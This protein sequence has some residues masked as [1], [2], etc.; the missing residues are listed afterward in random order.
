M[1]PRELVL[2]V[3]ARFES[4]QL[5]FGHG[6]DNARDEAV[7][8]VFHALG[9]PFDVDDDVL[10]QSLEDVQ[11][12]VVEKI[13]AERIKSRKPAAYLTGRMWFAGH[14]FH[15]D[16]RV[17]V[18]RS[19][20]AELIKSEFKPWLDPSRI[21]RVLEIGTGSGCIAIAAAIALPN[22][23]ID[24]TDNSADA[25]AVAALNLARY[26][27]LGDRIWFIEA[28]LFPLSNATYDLVVTNPPY[29][30]SGDVSTLPPEYAHEP[31]MALD[32]GP[33]GLTIV[34][35]ILA[36]A[37]DRLSEDG[38]I[39]IDVGEMVTAIDREIQ[40]VSFTWIDVEYGG[41]GIGIAYKRDFH[42]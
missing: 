38:A 36:Q 11:C 13:V 14:E 34:R 40:S 2:D 18:P 39:I 1:T 23:K 10:D 33:D 9:L 16:E 21:D 8:L 7:F 35:R 25:L 12:A 19:P 42:C 17:L 5:V 15:V 24:A 27:Q 20:I 4:A 29:V 3:E 37:A 6:T 31:S 26:P 22:A 32:A 41:E 30:P 28:D